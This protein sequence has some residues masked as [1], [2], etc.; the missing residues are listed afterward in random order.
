[1]TE[2]SSFGIPAGTARL[3]EAKPSDDHNV[4]RAALAALIGTMLENYDFVVY[5]TASALVFSEVFFPSISPQAGMIASFSAY[6]IG[7]L[8]RPL[9]GLFFSHYGETLGRKWVLVS[10]L[11]LMGGST[12]AIGCLPTYATFG[13]GAPILL[14]TCRFL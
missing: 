13:I 14:V 6:A 3:N 12:F 1:M 10:T 5:G 4:T 7:F 2:A 11:F 8:A 9:G